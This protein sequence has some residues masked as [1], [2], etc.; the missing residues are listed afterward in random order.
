MNSKW[1]RNIWLVFTVLMV[2]GLVLG[3]GTME[4]KRDKFLQEGKALYD[5][6]DYTRARLQFKNALQ[7]D[8]KF[9]LGLLWVAKTELKL[10]NFRGAFGTLQQALELDPKLVEARILLGQLYLGG[11]KFDEAKT[12]LKA[13]LAEEPQNVEAILLGATIS[14]LEGKPE[15]ARAKFKEVRGLDPK[16]F[17]VYLIQAQLEAYH[18]NFEAAAKAL[19]EG[20][21]AVPDKKELYLARAQLADAQKQ[22]AES[23]KYLKEAEKLDP[24]NVAVQAEL[25]RHYIAA[26][27]FDQAEQALQRQVQLE[28]DDEKHV[29]ALARFFVGLGKGKEAEQELTNFIAKHPDNTK[30]KFALAEL[31]TSRRQEGKALKTLQEIVDKD[32]TGPTGL[33]AKGRMAAMYA[34]RGRTAEAEKLAAEVLKE[35]PKDMATNRTMGLLAMNKK[36]GVSAVNNFRT[37]V[38]DQ[39][40]NVEARLFLAQ[41]HLLNKE[42]EQAREQAKKAL[43]LKP[44]SVEARR[45]LYGTYLQDKDYKGAI[46]FIQGYLRYNEKDMFNLSALGETYLIKGDLA[47]ARA[48]FNKMISLEPKNPLGYFE[49]ARMELKQKQTEPAIKYLVE[50]LNQNPEFIPALQLL[51]GMYLEQNKPVK[52]AEAVN[53]SL[54]RAPNNSVLLQMLGEI[55]LVQKKPQEAAQALEKAFTLNPRQLGALRLLILA[56]QQNPDTDKVAKELGAKANDPKA[57]KFYI[58][59]QAMYYERLK[60]YNKAIE[61]Y[62]QMIERNILTTLAKNNLAYLLATQMPSKENSQRALKLVS[63]ALDEAPDDANILDTKGWILCQQEEYRQAITYLEQAVEQGPENLALK[64]H[65]AFCQAKLGEVEKAKETLEKLLENKVNFTDRAA[66]ETL[67]LQLR[68]EKDKGKQ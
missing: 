61:V 32:P 1:I 29:V 51:I 9:A 60:D 24:K 18:K 14:M 59:A 63:E 34:A 64:Y 35:N 53:K 6:G 43:E 56:Y 62:N 68:S 55:S 10:E 36:D 47:A 16:K 4:Q 57:P 2:L 20:I 42:K 11:K 19:D 41:A 44:D 38:Q 3:C 67:L 39:P 28:P 65:L 21:K 31:Y 40:Q 50:A 46:D 15:E 66:A 25:A 30:A 54:A 45:F 5:K 26:Q 48:T 7:I 23:E 22:F 8:P 49:L 12:Q 27:Q 17:E 37:L 33:Q 52:A 13:A 58:L